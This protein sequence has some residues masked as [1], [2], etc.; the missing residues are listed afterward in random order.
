MIDRRNFLEIAL[1]AQAY[2]ALPARADMPGLRMGEAQPFPALIVCSS[3]GSI[4][5]RPG[6]G[7][8]Y[9]GSALALSFSSD[10]I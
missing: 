1:A 6:A 4:L 9:R 7:E 2:A 8:A 10:L 3:R 5:K